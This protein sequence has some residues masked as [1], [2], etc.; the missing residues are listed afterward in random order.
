MPREPKDLLREVKAPGTSSE[1]LA[2]LAGSTDAEVA[3]AAAARLTKAHVAEALAALS[4]GTA[5]EAV[6]LTLLTQAVKTMPGRVAAFSA[7]QLDEL[8]FLMATDE[9]AAL[10]GAA[11]RAVID[12]VVSAHGP[13]VKKIAIELA[14]TWHGTLDELMEASVHIHETTIR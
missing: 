7:E 8:V 1:R 3:R 5:P 12:I 2:E 14:P 10:L 6:A 11:T 9:E 4:S 13:E